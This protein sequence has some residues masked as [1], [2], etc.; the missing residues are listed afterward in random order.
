MITHI[1][2]TKTNLMRKLP[3]IAFVL[4]IMQYNKLVK[5]TFFRITNLVNESMSKGIVPTKMKAPL[6]TL[7]LKKPSMDK[8]AME[9]F[10]PLSNLSFISELTWRVVLK[11]LTVY[12]VHGTHWTYYYT[13]PA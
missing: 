9:N 1:C 4:P 10:R 13:S 5:N 7:L 2:F 12:T 8:N 11:R 3:Q 6:V